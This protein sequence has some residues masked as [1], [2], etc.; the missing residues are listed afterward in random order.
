MKFGTLV[1]FKMFCPNLLGA[2]A[3][4]QWC[5]HIGQFKMVTHQKLITFFFGVSCHEE[6][7]SSIFFTVVLIEIAIFEKIIWPTVKV[8]IS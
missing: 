3:N 7:E 8:E 1:L 6:S 2:K 5:R 4:F